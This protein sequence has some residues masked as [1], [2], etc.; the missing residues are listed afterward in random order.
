[1][2]LLRVIRPCGVAAIPDTLMVNKQTT[3]MLGLRG[4]RAKVGAAVTDGFSRGSSTDGR[5]EGERE[6]KEETGRKETTCSLASEDE[7][8]MSCIPDVF[9][10]APSLA[11]AMR[12]QSK[13]DVTWLL[14]KNAA[15][16]LYAPY[17]RAQR[18]SLNSAPARGRRRSQRAGCIR[19]FLSSL[20]RNFGDWS[21]FRPAS[22]SLGSCPPP[23]FPRLLLPSVTTAHRCERL[24]SA[25]A[26]R[27]K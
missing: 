21:H 1:M 8:C 18:W 3:G 27:K 26:A 13:N 10:P 12:R 23:S 19:N 17:G 9:E 14:P 6:S 16:H 11:L 20:L 25:G 4:R 2:K 7:T 5:R 15:L 22:L 24:A